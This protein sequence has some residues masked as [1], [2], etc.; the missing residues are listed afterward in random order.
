MENI[1]IIKVNKLDTLWDQLLPDFS[2]G[3]GLHDYHITLQIEN[4]SIDLDIS[5]SPGGNVEGG[6]ENTQIHAA[7]PAHPGF[8][9]VIYPEDFI[10][11]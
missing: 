6:Y 7:L 8:V 5:S 1:K 10:T 3:L 2:T 4:H 11:G 9:F